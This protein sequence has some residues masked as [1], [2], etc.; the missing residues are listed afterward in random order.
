MAWHG[1]ALHWMHGPVGD[2]CPA[3]WNKRAQAAQRRLCGPPCVRCGRSSTGS[4]SGET[5]LID[6]IAP[7]PCHIVQTTS[8][9]RGRASTGG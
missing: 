3:I 4:L 5:L 7:G 6:S 8:L 1:I 9:T 2:G